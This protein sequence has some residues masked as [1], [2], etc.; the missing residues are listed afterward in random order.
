MYGYIRNGVRYIELDEP[1]ETFVAHS[2]TWGEDEL[3]HYKYVKRYQVDGK[4]RYVYADKDTHK[5]IIESKNNIKTY[6]D[7]AQDAK[8]NLISDAKDYAFAKEFARNDQRRESARDFYSKSFDIDRY[9]I[10]ENNKRWRESKYD[11]DRLTSANS[12]KTLATA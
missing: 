4:W 6:Y 3:Y 11:Y 8:K 2:M 9:W 5:S 10:N 1:I 12:V 7:R